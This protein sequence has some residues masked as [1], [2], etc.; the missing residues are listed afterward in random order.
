[1][2][3]NDYVEQLEYIIELDVL[4]KLT[5]SEKERMFADLLERV[6]RILESPLHL[7]ILEPEEEESLRRIRLKIIQASH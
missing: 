1:M 4:G 2:S 5:D 6:C 3:F 7:Q